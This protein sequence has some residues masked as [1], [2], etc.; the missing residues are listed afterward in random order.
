MIAWDVA[1]MPEGVKAA[2]LWSNNYQPSRI[3]SRQFTVEAGRI[4]PAVVAGIRTG[5]AAS[6][7]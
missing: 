2:L 3:F 1:I 5:S 7:A 4:S 6:A